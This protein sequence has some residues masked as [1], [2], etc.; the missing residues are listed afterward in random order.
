MRAWAAWEGASDPDPATLQPK[1][2]HNTLHVRASCHFRV[3]RR[4]RDS[5][6]VTRALS[7]AR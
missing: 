2:P 5:K 3:Q 1:H 4:R 6:R 7:V